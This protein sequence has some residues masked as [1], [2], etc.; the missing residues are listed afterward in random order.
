MCRRTSIHKL[1]PE[2][3]S[4]LIREEAGMHAPGEQWFAEGTAIV[5]EEGKAGRERLVLYA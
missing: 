4:I 1:G 3:L 2:G 5:C